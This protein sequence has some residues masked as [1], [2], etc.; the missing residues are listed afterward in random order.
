METLQGA[1]LGILLII[2]MGILRSIPTVNLPL[3]F[4]ETLL[5]D[6]ASFPCPTLLWP[7]RHLL[8]ILE[9]FFHRGV[10]G[11]AIAQATVLG[12][13]APNAM[14][15][16]AITASRQEALAV[17]AMTTRAAAGGGATTT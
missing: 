1:A 14:A 3:I 13:D 7:P 6:M 10:I 15:A 5:Q 17:S 4:M 16:P 11:T 9:I 8:L 12:S 2:L